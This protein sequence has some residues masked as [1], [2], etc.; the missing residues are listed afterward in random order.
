MTKRRK[1]ELLWVLERPETRLHTNAPERDLRGFIIKRKISGGTVSRNGRQA[2]DSMIGLMN[3]SKAQLSFWHDLSDRWGMGDD[4]H[5][6][7]PLLPWLR[8]A[9]EAFPCPWAGP[10]TGSAQLTLSY[11]SKVAP[12]FWLRRSY[13]LQF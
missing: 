2:S 12:P 5:P 11:S 10:A 4:D 7:P 1:P 13:C 3:L 8:H 6:V 9:P